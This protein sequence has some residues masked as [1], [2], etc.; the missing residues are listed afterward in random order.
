MGVVSE[1]LLELLHHLK[2]E[3]EYKKRTEIA[4]ELV[5]QIE[6]EGNFPDANYAFDSGGDG[7]VKLRL[8]EMLNTETDSLTQG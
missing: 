7:V 8:W 5:Q 3:R 1:R 4:L 6:E 2:H